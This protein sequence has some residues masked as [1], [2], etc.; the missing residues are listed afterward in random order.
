MEY[1]EVQ[2][3]ECGWQGDSGD[4]ILDDEDGRYIHCPDCHSTD[5]EDYEDLL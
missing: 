3:N 5:I 2:C 1:P 4:L